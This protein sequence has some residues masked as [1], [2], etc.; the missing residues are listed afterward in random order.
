[1]SDESVRPTKGGELKKR[2]SGN[3]NVRVKQAAQPL[4]VSYLFRKVAN[5]T[6]AIQDGGANLTMTRLEALIRQIH[7]L[8][9]NNNPS[10]ARLLHRMR[11]QF[12][13]KAAPGEILSV[14]SDADMKL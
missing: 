3:P 4:S 13:E 11:K 7:I 12:P 8:A 14:I 6:I 1:M 9:L 5:E 10:A 2:K